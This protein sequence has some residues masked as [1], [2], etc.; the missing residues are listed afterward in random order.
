MTKPVLKPCPFC[1]GTNQTIANDDSDDVYVECPGCCH[2]FPDGPDYT[3]LAI[4]VWNRRAGALDSKKGA[5]SIL[6]E[7]TYCLNSMSKEEWG[8]GEDVEYLRGAIERIRDA[9]QGKPS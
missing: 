6:G 5:W 9:A 2:V 8:T 1:G 4:E 7:A 3:R